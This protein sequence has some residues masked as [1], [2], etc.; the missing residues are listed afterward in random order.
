M[1]EKE[2][3]TEADMCDVF[4]K[5]VPDTWII[6]PETGGFD[7]LLV[8]KEDGFQIGI[9]AKLHLNAKVISQAAEEIATWYA[10]SPGPDCRAVLVP[11]STGRALENV[12]KLLGI[13]VI[14][15]YRREIYYPER[16]HVY[17]ILPDLP[18]QSWDMN[19]DDG[20]GWFEYFPKERVKVPD[21]IPD[22]GAGNPCPITLTNWKIKAI[23]LSITL[24]KRGYLERDDF[25]FFNI[26][27]SRW[28]QGGITA[29]LQ[30]SGRG[31]W[32]KGSRF[33]DLRIQHP[34]NYEQIYND[35]EEWKKP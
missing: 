13:Q 19:A 9:E 31:K 20:R 8:R 16:N 10:C 5:L 12:C 6:Y 27:I 7:I 4:I 24:E 18:K 11:D 28:T 1:T 21:Y 3:K 34:I 2:F 33:P 15:L 14:R 32:V 30:P 23:K 17:E 22:T 35:Y 29:W 25:K 26:S